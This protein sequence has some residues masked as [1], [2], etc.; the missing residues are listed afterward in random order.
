MDEPYTKTAINLRNVKDPDAWL[1]A[2]ADGEEIP[3]P[4]GRTDSSLSVW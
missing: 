4:V 3:E 1:Y 2:C